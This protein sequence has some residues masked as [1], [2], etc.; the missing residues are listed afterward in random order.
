MKQGN[1]IYCK[2]TGGA[3]APC[4]YLVDPVVESGDS[5]EDG[6]FVLIVAAEAR[7]E[8]GDA[9]NLPGT[10]GVLTVQR[11]ARVALDTESEA[12]SLCFIHLVELLVD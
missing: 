4:F 5:G 1:S 2:P 9:V 11:A 6:G 8:A 10:C 3:P 7:N 12:E